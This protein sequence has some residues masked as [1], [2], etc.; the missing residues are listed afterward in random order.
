M[1]FVELKKT[2]SPA[3]TGFRSGDAADELEEEL[4]LLL[5]LLLDEPPLY[6]LFAFARFAAAA[7]PA[8]GTG[9]P[10]VLTIKTWMPLP[11]STT[12]RYLFLSLGDF[13]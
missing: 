9:S 7:A 4:L 6:L 5:L 2:F 1:A 3:P 13:V 8:P 11:G 10:G 12:C